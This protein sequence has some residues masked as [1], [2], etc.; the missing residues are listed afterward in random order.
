ME[1]REYKM[2]NV[3]VTTRETEKTEAGISITI[4]GT[5]LMPLQSY[6]LRHPHMTALEIGRL[7]EGLLEKKA[8]I[9]RV[10]GNDMNMGWMDEYVVLDGLLDDIRPRGKPSAF[11][12]T[13]KTETAF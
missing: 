10:T 12:G 9:V 8:V 2:S 3:L 13:I 7:M 5:E 11:D 1:K 6:L 4:H